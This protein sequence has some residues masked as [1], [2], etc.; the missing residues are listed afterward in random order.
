MI[1]EIQAKVLLAHV[2][3]PDTTFGLKYNMNLYRGCQ[4]Q[5]IYCD[6]RSECYGIENFQDVL[7]KTNAIELLRKE[8]ASKRIKGSIGTGSMHDPYMPAEKEFNLTGQAL[9]VISEFR[10]PVHIN[11]KSDLILRDLDVLCEVNRVHASVCFS[12]TTADDDLGK[13]VEP[14]APLV[15]ARFKAMEVLAAHGIHVGVAMMPVLPFI[16]DS[17]DNIAAIVKETHAHGGTFIIPW[18]GM[19]L[20]DRQ[21]AYYYDKLDRL[22]PGLTRRYERAYGNQYQCPIPNAD[23]L[24][25]VFTELCE[26]FRILTQVKHY[27]PET[28]KQ[29]SLF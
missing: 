10:F 18:L 5:C 27:E 14:G 6:S 29:L 21:R 16:E 2:K 28:A 7:V 22:F 1:R 13:K 11:T 24:W 26:Q 20:R 9:Q 8:L 12:I 15:S 25:A 17:E 4:H 19:S 23:R 3:Q